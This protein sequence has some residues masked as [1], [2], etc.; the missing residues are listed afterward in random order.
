MSEAIERSVLHLKPNRRLI[1]SRSLLAGAAGLLPVPYLDDLLAS[2]ARAAL[3]RRLGD[4]RSV[5]LDAN[6][7][8]ELASPRGGRLLGAA[9]VGALAIGG[10]RRAWRRLATSLLMVRRVDEAVQTFHVATLF[11]HYCARHHV[12]LGLDGR[13]ATVLRAAIEEATRAAQAET[14]TRAFR[15]GLRA[16]ATLALKLWRRPQRNA[17]PLEAE[18]LDPVEARLARAERSGLL[19]RAVRGVEAE[20]TA[21]ELSYVSGLVAAFEIAWAKKQA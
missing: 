1:L 3:I 5:D 6:A 17:E 8:D 16:P 10:T 18:P 7:V 15:R 2:A 4:L 9:S 13:R 21:L 12:G 19:R 11:D 20:L 14:L